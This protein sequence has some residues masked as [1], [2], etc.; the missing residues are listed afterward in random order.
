[1]HCIKLIKLAPPVAWIVAVTHAAWT[2]CSFKCILFE[3]INFILMKISLML[4]FRVHI[5]I[6]T[7]TYNGLVQA[8]IWTNN[9]PV[10]WHQG[11]LLL[12]WINFNPSTDKYSHSH[13]SVGWNSLSILKLQR[14]HRLGIV[15]EWISNFIPHFM[16][17]VIA[18]PC[19]YL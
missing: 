4:F 6:N 7:G 12:K 13:E 17:D 18:K 8:I 5:W 2:K 3:R 10:W 15:W 19:W 1:M 16:V 11:P 14:L 9:D